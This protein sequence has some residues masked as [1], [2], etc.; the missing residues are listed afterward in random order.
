MSGLL[1]KMKAIRMLKAIV[2]HS[3][4]FLD[5]LYISAFVAA[6]TIVPKEDSASL[7]TSIL[8]FAAG[9]H[10]GEL[11]ITA[12]IRLWGKEDTKGE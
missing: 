10:G 6:C 7:I 11:M 1:S 2:W 4:I 3:M 8:T 5:L 9:T 12:A